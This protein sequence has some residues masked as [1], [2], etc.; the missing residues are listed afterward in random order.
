MATYR[1]YVPAFA[2]LYEEAGSDLPAFY[3]LSKEIADLP[4]DERRKRMDSYLAP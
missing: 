1:R 2:A 4:F 3:A